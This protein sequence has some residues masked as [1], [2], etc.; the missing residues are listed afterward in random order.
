[1][2]VSCFAMALDS[3]VVSS[4]KM[5][6]QFEN[7]TQQIQ[8]EIDAEVEQRISQQQV[9]IHTDAFFAVVKT[10][11]ALQL[12]TTGNKD[13]AIKQ[14]DKVHEKLNKLIEKGHKVQ[15]EPVL[16]VN[17]VN[18]SLTS[19][20]EIQRRKQNIN[21]QWQLGHTQ[22]VRYL[23]NHFVSDT[24]IR[25]LHMSVQRFVKDIKEINRLISDSK[26][27]K[28]KHL[29]Q[30][31]LNSLTASDYTIPLPLF[32]AELM[33]TKAQQLTQQVTNTEPVDVNQLN[34]LLSNAKYQLKLAEAFGYG[35][36][37]RY[38]KFFQAIK[39]IKS[40]VKANQQTAKLFSKLKYAI[41]N[42]KND[43][44]EYK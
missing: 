23:L 36:S 39:G 19:Y 3:A 15:S 9:L 17:L 33:I 12:L 21:A 4:I 16:V 37:K 43:V 11:E 27:E 22:K 38:A 13:A 8:I 2:A 26:I 35:D 29:I 30:A 34:L 18:D 41:L 42:L 24:S 44:I 20:D 40:L 1:M 31:L 32:R 7:I 14:L 25:T 5:P 6:Q 28:A 10:S